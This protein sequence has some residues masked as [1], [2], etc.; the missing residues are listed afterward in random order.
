MLHY[1]TGNSPPG[2]QTKPITFKDLPEGLIY[3]PTYL[4]RCVQPL[5][6]SFGTN[7]DTFIEAGQNLKA[8]NIPRG[9]AGVHLQ[10]LP[11]IGINIALW[12]G[13]DELPA[14]GTVY[15][16]SDIKNY[17]PTEDIAVL[18]QSISLKIVAAAATN[19]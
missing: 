1:L 9:D 17:L 10:A 13:D 4:K 8:V 14:E 12:L 2:L 15:F 5:I 16:S 7:L 19:H 3:Y 11:R 18:C 6:E